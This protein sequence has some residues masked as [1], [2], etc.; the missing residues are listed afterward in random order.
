MAE[1]NGPV[2][3]PVILILKRNQGRGGRATAGQG[4]ARGGSAAPGQAK[5]TGAVLCRRTSWLA[6]ENRVHRE[7]DIVVPARALWAVSGCSQAWHRM[8]QLK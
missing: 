5:A 4:L 1:V 6:R 2:L 8:L 7:C 3:P